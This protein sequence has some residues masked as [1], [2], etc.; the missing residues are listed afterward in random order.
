MVSSPNGDN[1]GGDGDGQGCIPVGAVAKLAATVL[2]NAPQD[3][4][5]FHKPGGIAPSHRHDIRCDPD[6]PADVN[7]GSVAQLAVRVVPPAIEL[8]ICDGKARRTADH[9]SAHV[10]DHH[11]V[12]AA[13]GVLKGVEAD[14]AARP[15]RQQ[16]PIPHPLITVGRDPRVPD[17][18]RDGLPDRHYL[19]YRLVGD[20]KGIRGGPATECPQPKH[21]RHQKKQISEYP[22]SGADIRKDGLAC[23]HGF[24]EGG[25]FSRKSD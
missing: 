13:V 8:H 20:H 2:A 9:D 11:L 24:L 15:G 7:S 18:D 22:G 25:F 17:T 3:P 10:A 1:V 23:V 5:A 16:D 4:V 6:R 19:T 12:G 14:A 21:R